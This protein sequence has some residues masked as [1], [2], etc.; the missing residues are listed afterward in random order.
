MNHCGICRACCRAPEISELQKPEWKMCQHACATGCGIYESRPQSCRDYRCIWLQS[1]GG[2]GALPSR[3]RPDRCGVIFDQPDG[4]ENTGL[5]VAR[6]A[7]GQEE[8]L[9]GSAVAAFVTEL[10][11]VG[12]RIVTRVGGDWGLA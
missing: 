12:F 1:Q 8:K 4:L 3:L 9:R 10:K 5:I 2:P 11:R 6:A 7:P